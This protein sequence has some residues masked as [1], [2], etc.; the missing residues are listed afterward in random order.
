MAFAFLLVELLK[1]VNAIKNVEAQ[2]CHYDQS[3]D[4][5]CC[6]ALFIFCFSWPQNSKS[7]RKITLRSVKNV[8]I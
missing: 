5:K 7:E 8:L 4:L 6:H 3:D 1:V 2:K